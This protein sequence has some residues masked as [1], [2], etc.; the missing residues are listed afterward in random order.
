MMYGCTESRVP[1]VPSRCRGRDYKA[2]ERS[3]SAR[4]VPAD[5][6]ETQYRHR[7]AAERPVSCCRK[8]SSVASRG[9]HRTRR[10][11]RVRDFPVP[12]QRRTSSIAP[13]SRTASSRNRTSAFGHGRCAPRQS[14]PNPLDLARQERFEVEGTPLFAPLAVAGERHVVSKRYFLY[15]HERESSGRCGLR[16]T[17]DAP[18]VCL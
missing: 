7:A 11:D 9:T 17:A 2:W 8:E 5:A 3:G 14:P 1:R 15:S 12:G 16:V 6:D 4:P 13:E 18:S 10:H